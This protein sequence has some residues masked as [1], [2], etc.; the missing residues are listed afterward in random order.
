M[1]S[2]SCGLTGLRLLLCAL[3]LRICLITLI[4]RGLG[5][6][7]VPRLAIIPSG[8]TILPSPRTIE[9]AA[10]AIACVSFCYVREVF[11]D[12]LAGLLEDFDD[13]ARKVSI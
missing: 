2:I 1:I 4:G 3:L 7:V 8:I 11:R 13:L 9:C 12:L 5:I 6:L 10:P